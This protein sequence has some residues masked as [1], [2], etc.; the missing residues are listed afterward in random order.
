MIRAVYDTSALIA[1]LVVEHPHNASS[2][3]SFEREHE[4][5]LCSTH[6]L[7]E[8]YRG[9]TALPIQPRITPEQ[10]LRLIR[11]RILTAATVISLDDEDYIAT[12]ERMASLGLVSGAIYD[13]L[14]VRAAEKIGADELV[15][16]NERDFERMPPAPPCKL[17]VLS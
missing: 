14:H 17:V 15:T 9:L 10:A 6:A 11:E 16:F 13:G 4:E 3:E 5:R 7:A 12:L 1:L 2:T 8:T